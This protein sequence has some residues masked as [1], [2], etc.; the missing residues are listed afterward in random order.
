MARRRDQLPKD[1]FGEHEGNADLLDQFGVAFAD[2]TARQFLLVFQSDC[3]EA[4]MEILVDDFKKVVED[5]NVKRFEHLLWAFRTVVEQLAN[6][7]YSRSR[8]LVV[9]YERE[10]K[11]SGKKATGAGLA[12]YFRA[13]NGGAISDSY[14]CRLLRDRRAPE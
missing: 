13:N 4:E 6:G 9:Q 14:A 12:R 5:R 2:D 3:P 11:D 8:Q 7:P 10:A 1:A